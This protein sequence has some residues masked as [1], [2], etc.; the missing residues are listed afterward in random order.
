MI[1]MKKLTKA[2]DFTVLGR[3]LMSEKPI[4]E[5]GFCTF[6]NNVLGML[7]SLSPL[8]G[9][10][11]LILEIKKALLQWNSPSLK[12]LSGSRGRGINHPILLSLHPGKIQ[13]EYASY[14]VT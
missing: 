2:R 13:E 9:V 1:F 10:E 4:L 14:S 7:H 11:N 6:F 12:A 8:T 3:S 5:K